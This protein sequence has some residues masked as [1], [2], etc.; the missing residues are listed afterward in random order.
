LDWGKVAFFWGEV[1]Q[2]FTRNITMAVA[3]IGTVA[4]AIVLLG[5]FLFLRESFDLMIHSVAGQINVRAYLKDDIAQSEITAMQTALRADPRVASVRLITKKQAMLDLRRQM[6]GQMNLD[7][8]NTN[9]LPNSLEIVPRDPFDAPALA[10]AMELKPGVATVK[11]GG[12]VT[13]KLL[14]V[15]SVSSVAG[16]GIISLL[17][18][19]TA[20]LIYN[21]TRLTVFARQRE[22]G[23]MQLVGATRWTVRWP[24]VL[25]GILSGA[26]G[27]LI[28]IAMLWLGYR[29]LVPKIALSLPFLPFKL[30]NVAVGHLALELVVVGAIVGMLAS[31]L[32][33]GRYLRTA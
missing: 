6:R 7:V 4:I 14:K 28:G 30:E 1:A 13:E 26:T 5:V 32:S 15:E 31:L 18:I 20:L 2:N 10:A 27:A 12:T 22:I 19:A 16:V 17:M 9:P 8:L 11:D 29:T 33:V 3:A 23:I 21:T 24:F 25:E